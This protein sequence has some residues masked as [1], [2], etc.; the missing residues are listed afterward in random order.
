MISPLGIDRC[1]GA[2]YKKKRRGEIGNPWGVPTEAGEGRL[3]E[4]WK[5]RVQVLSD[6]KE[7][8][9]STI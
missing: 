1:K 4:S 3:G 2:T 8:T 5:T 9:Q 6:R 7:K